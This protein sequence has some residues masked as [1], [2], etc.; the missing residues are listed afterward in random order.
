[1]HRFDYRL[2]RQMLILAAVADC[3]SFSRAAKRLSISQPP[4]IAQVNELEARLGV[5]FLTR[6]RAGVTLTPEGEALLPGIRRLITQAEALDYSARTIRKDAQAI[7]RIG[8]VYEAMVTAVPALIA[9]AR[10]LL[11]GISVFTEEIDSSEAE[12][13]LSQ[14]EI[15]IAFGRFEAFR[16]PGLEMRAVWREAPVLAVPAGSPLSKKKSAALRDLASEE[17]IMTGREKCPEYAD[18]VIGFFAKAGYSPRVRCEVDSIA[19]QVA[20]V[21]CGLG[22]AM[23]PETSAARLPDAAAALP[24]RSPKME[25]VMNSAWNGA[26]ENLARDRLLALLFESGEEKA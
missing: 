18:R 19:R 2:I 26:E 15:H 4:L 11:P 20:F 6:T 22:V 24:F 7:I 25:L 13:K 8:A 10:R 16:A 3:G 12:Y 21:S 1:M 23:I 17:W 14:N 9:K 5:R